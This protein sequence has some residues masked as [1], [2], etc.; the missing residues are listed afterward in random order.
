[1][2]IITIKGE[3]T[4]LFAA[5]D[6]FVEFVTLRLELVLKNEEMKITVEKKIKTENS[7]NDYNRVLQLLTTIYK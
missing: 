4:D 1:V 2:K 7:V 6:D 3:S 5:L